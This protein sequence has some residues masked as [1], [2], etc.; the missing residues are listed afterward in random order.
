MPGCYQYGESARVRVR[1]HGSI[2]RLTARTGGGR[3]VTVTRRF[4][5]CA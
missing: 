5:A 1:R 4:R 2:V 3:K